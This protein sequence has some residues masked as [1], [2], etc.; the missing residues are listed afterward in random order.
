MAGCWRHDGGPVD[1]AEIAQL[2]APIVHRGPDDSGIW[3]QGQ[4]GLGHRRLSIIDLSAAGHQP[5]LTPD[6]GSVL[7]YNGEIYNYR[8]L[9]AELERAGAEFRG[10]SDAEVL[11]WALHLWGPE[12][13]IPR[14]NG[15][16]AFAYY[17]ARTKA[18]W[19]AR[20]RLG[21]KQ[22]YIHETEREVH[23][24]SEV[25]ALRALDRLQ[26][27]IDREAV[28]R[29]FLGLVRGHSSLYG[30]VGGL[31]PGSWWRIDRDGIR[32]HRYFDIE[33]S[34]DADRLIA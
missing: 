19:L 23:F 26:I 22:L 2:L 15:M 21:I 33:S 5:M 16:F 29:R 12:Q 7:S 34:L 3:M 10:H 8:E 6:G 18:L 20:D 32:R 11:L 27:D 28:R 4:V 13:A 31:P 17:D 24:A 14:L 25:K 30:N 9:R 1:P